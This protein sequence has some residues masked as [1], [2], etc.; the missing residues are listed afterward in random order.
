MK[1]FKRYISQTEYDASE[2]IKRKMQLQWLRKK[3]DLDGYIKLGVDTN[4]YIKNNFEKD[5]EYYMEL[6]QLFAK[7]YEFRELSLDESGNDFCFV[8]N[9]YL[10]KYFLSMKLFLFQRMES[11]EYSSEIDITNLKTFEK[12]VFEY[13]LTHKDELKKSHPEIYLRYVSILL[14]K[15]GFDNTLYD[16]YINV[17]SKTETRM[18]IN[19]YGLL[20][21]LLNTISKF[22]NS[23]KQDLEDKVIE[24]AELLIT[25]NLV[26]RKGIGHVDLKIIIEAAIKIKK[27]DW[28]LEYMRKVKD[29]IKYENPRN[30]YDMLSAK[31]LFFR[32]DF[33]NARLLL[34]SITTDDYIFYC[35]AKLIECRI[36]FIESDY[37]SVLQILET[38]KKYLK[39]HKEIGVHFIQSYNI[40]ANIM[41]RLSEMI[42]RH[43]NKIDFEFMLLSLE[44]EVN[45]LNKPCYAH[46]WI[47]GQIEKMKAG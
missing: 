41:K 33:K 5:E 15:S 45:S 4:N 23:G 11:L 1:L 3:K 22:I 18:N 30:A 37:E 14:N 16:E 43:H 47:M 42:S 13:I 24:V 17:L 29:H 35:E 9:D 34:S 6:V 20:L 26:N 8:I 27:F 39:S 28:A 44:K 2:L 12:G 40:F 7:I 32:N 38:V 46:R 10:D 36:S 19:D 25:R 21:T 31:I